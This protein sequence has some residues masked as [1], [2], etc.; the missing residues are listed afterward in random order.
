[1]GNKNIA[2]FV[3][4]T[5]ASGDMIIG[6]LIDTG[7]NSDL[8]LNKI[9]EV[10]DEAGEIDI[11][12]SRTTRNS[13]SGLRVNINSS[14]S[15]L[16]FGEMLE[17]IKDSSL[18]EQ[19]KEKSIQVLRNL[20][21]AEDKVHRDFSGFHEVGKV[22]AL[23][24]IVGSIVGYYDLG[25]NNKEVYCTELKV[26]GGYTETEHGLLSAPTP[27]TLEILK[28]NKMKFSGG[29][30][31]KEILTP[32]GAAILSVFI[33]KFTTFF[34]PIKINRIGRG[35][36]KMKLKSPNLLTLCIGESQGNLIEDSVG[37][38]ET[39]IDDVEGEDV[40]YVIEKLLEEGALDV[41]V[42]PALMKKSRMGN[43]L[44]VIS[45]KEDLEKLS[46]IIIEETGTLGVR[47]SEETHR[48]IAEREF[49]IVKIFDY[50]VK[51]KIGRFKNGRI[52]DISPEYDDCM[53]IA[54]KTGKPLQQIK[55]IAVNKAME[56]IN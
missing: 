55:K 26:G 7:A 23:A 5:G 21:E 18:N 47:V 46:E 48:L 20:K 2:I 51:V 25:L 24:D 50:K 3:P 36:G 38:L 12:V 16:S 22:D 49:K 40:G 30:V 10:A 42:V 17:I 44:K 32:T 6:S 14:D 8:I 1:M 39:N 52:I 4:S 27:A 19:S 31:T 34:P 45:K 11:N 43:I 35:A 9:K 29:P 28:E 41:S 37:M 33:D 15:K 53:K 54:K 56:D 13:V